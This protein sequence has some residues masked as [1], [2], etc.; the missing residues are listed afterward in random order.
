MESLGIGTAPDH[1]NRSSR[2]EHRPRRYS[3]ED[4]YSDDDYRS[5]DRGGGRRND[6]RSAQDGPGQ[7]GQ[8]A[9]AAFT[10]A[11]LEAWKARK[12][13]GGW[14]GEKGRR[15]LTAAASAGGIDGLQDRSPKDHGI[16]NVLSSAIGGLATNRLANGPVS[17]PRDS[18]GRSRS[19]GG[20]ERGLKDLAAG[21]I[22]AGFGKK[23]LDS[24]SK[25]RER[26]RERDRDRDRG[27]GRRDDTPSDSEDDYR[28][29]ASRGSR[30]PPPP[31][32]SKS[33]T[34]QFRDRVAEGLASLGLNDAAR[35][36]EPRDEA[37][38]NA[39]R[40]TRELPRKDRQA[41][42]DAYDGQVIRRS[43]SHNGIAPGAA[44]GAGQGKPAPRARRGSS[45]SSGGDCDKTDP[46]KS[47]YDSDV[48]RRKHK[49]LREKEVL[50]G[51]LATVATVHSVHS[52]MEAKEA[53]QRRHAKVISGE[54]TPAQAKLEARKAT[55]KDLATIGIVSFPILPANSP[56][57]MP[58]E[59]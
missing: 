32:R 4:D 7:I 42:K 25:S 26:E 41:A 49:K 19:T 8:A 2:R 51:A 57:V 59:N 48:A 29:R 3:S 21:A 14:T 5:R 58:L 23:I 34:D 39:G 33:I 17:K 43:H 50:N 55:A 36:I 1:G 27:R 22:A 40:R 37:R 16:G 24:R 35:K 47:D 13:P 20:G 54:L 30:R 44:V 45:A 56:R 46:E 10:A 38:S 15:I 28:S 12:A 53:R 31:Q 9:Q 6:R 18:H 52:L 11:A